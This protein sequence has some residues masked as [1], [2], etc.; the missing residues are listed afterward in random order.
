[1]RK[2]KGGTSTF[3]ADSKSIP[4]GHIPGRPFDAKKAT[5][6]FAPNTG[7]SSLGGKEELI[8]RKAIF[9]AR[10]DAIKKK[11]EGSS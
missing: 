8:P 5:A 3:V 9:Q 2:G 11:K 1:L 4:P 10:R 6:I 7:V